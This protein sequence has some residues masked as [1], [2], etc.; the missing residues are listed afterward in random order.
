MA[1]SSKIFGRVMQQ[2]LVRPRI[3]RAIVDRAARLLAPEN[4]R[5]EVGPFEIGADERNDPL[6]LYAHFPFCASACKY[7]IF[8]KT[9][10]TGL[11]DRYVDAL[12][13]EIDLYAREPGLDRR[14]VGSIHLGGGT[15]SLVPAA[16]IARVLERLEARLGFTDAIQITL[17]GNPESLTPERAAGYRAVGVDRIS[18]GVQSFDD[19]LLRAMGRTH[20]RRTAITAIHGLRRAGIE[21]VSADLIYGFEGQTTAGFAD[22][23][24]TVVDLGLS[25]VSAFPLIGRSVR[26]M[27]SAERRHRDARHREMYLSLVEKTATA[28][29]DQYSSEDFALRPEAE[30]KYQ[31]DAWRFPKRDVLALGVGSLGTLNGAF[32]SNIPA[33]E[34]Y[35]AAIADR[36]LPVA[37]HKRV[38]REEERRRAVLLGAKYVH[39][40]RR[41]FV[42]RYG[43]ELETA[44]EPL[45]GRFQGLG[46]WT[47]DERGVH[48]TRDG[49]QTISEIWSELIL[50]NLAH[51]ARSAEH[52]E[53]AA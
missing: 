19:D 29:Y 25:H 46:V 17:E 7:C 33:I 23:L 28:G 2:E 47:V 22:D 31:I 14:R 32:Y 24:C 45:L 4:Q 40:S 26:E 43:I 49:L 20:G 1:L 8:K 52:E 6:A 5:Y 39:V 38:A 51:A 37:R 27:N 53:A 10:N 21:N 50:A 48:L 11:I 18:I 3:Q 30:S 35:I 44:L 42:E 12:L 13:D 36:R 34:R 9:V 16:Q 15:P 41:A